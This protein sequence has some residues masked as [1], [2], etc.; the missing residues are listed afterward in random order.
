MSE[1]PCRICKVE[2]QQNYAAISCK[3][4]NKWNHIN[5]VQVN[6]M[7]YEKRKSDTTPWHCPPGINELL[8]ANTSKSDFVYLYC[9]SPPLSVSCKPTVKPLGKKAKEL[10]KRIKDLNH[11]CDQSENCDYFHIKDLK[12]VKIKSQDLSILHLNISSI[13]SQI[14]DLKIFLN[15]LNTTFEI[16]CISE[17]RFSQKLPQATNIQLPGYNIEHTPTLSAAGG[18]LMYI[19]EN[20]SHKPRN[21]LQIS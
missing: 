17:S 3:L 15:L 21:D 13:S 1:Y 16:I 19:S 6:L 18:P 2:V 7:T 20:L 9:S 11:I 12:K 14:N 4:C 10:L 5:C 8:F